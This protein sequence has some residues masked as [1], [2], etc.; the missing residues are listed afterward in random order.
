MTSTQ[1]MA[2]SMLINALTNSAYCATSNDRLCSLANVMLISSTMGATAYV[3]THHMSD[4]SFSRCFSR[5]CAM[6]G[7]RYCL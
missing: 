2:V 6:I 5:V 7:W 3:I 1:N 4:G